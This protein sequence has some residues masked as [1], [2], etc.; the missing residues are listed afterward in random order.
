[1]R[2]SSYAKTDTG[3]VRKENQDAFGVNSDK[4]FFIVCDGMGGG[5]AGAC[6]A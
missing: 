4:D 5:A 3:I 6:G 1:M 2:I